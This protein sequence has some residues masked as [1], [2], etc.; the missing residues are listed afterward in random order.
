M[1][2][3]GLLHTCDLTRAGVRH[4]MGS[5]VP[6]TV[7]RAT[8]TPTASIPPGHI[9]GLAGGRDRTGSRRR[10]LPLLGL[11]LALGLVVVGLLP[12]GRAAWPVPRDSGVNVVVGPV[13]NCQG[14]NT[15][16]HANG[17]I[18]R[19]ALCP[20]GHTDGGEQALLRADAAAAFL[21]LSAAW[22]A[23]HGTPLCLRSAYRTYAEQAGLY[24]RMPG[25]AA[26]PGVSD[27]GWGTA[28][29]LCGGVQDPLSQ[30]HAWMVQ[31]GPE[32]G[33]VEPDWAQAGGSRPEPWHW[34]YEHSP[35][36]FTG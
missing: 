4:L 19:R 9:P 25:I 32:H 15:A 16:G 36:T 20:V 34:E 3:R 29:D 11:G 8:N 2:E 10:V 22:E 27:H 7:T 18:P 23:D 12:V 5:L 14:A 28:V 17:R 26:P 33:W 13:G 24:A 6:M 30:Q 31:H 1:R 35:R 21:S